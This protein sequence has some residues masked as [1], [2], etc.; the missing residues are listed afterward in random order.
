M[1]ISSLLQHH[2]WSTWTLLRVRYCFAKK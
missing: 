1:L 2:Y